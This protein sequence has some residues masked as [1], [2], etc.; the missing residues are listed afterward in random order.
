MVKTTVGK[1]A[2]GICDRSGLTFKLRELRRQTVD[3]KDSG[4]RVSPAMLDVDQPQNFLGQFPIN[5][6]QALPFTRTDTNVDEQRKIAWN[7]DPVG[8]N[9]GL[10]ALY[11]FSSQ[12]ST[13]ATG[14]V[15]TVAVSIT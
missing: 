3:G 4:L 1:Y 6:S 11:G 12:T 13:Q 14:Q 5:D 15:G 2:L 9:N 7:W 8:D 10:S